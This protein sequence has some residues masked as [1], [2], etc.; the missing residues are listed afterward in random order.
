MTD[1][2][3][4]ASTQAIMRLQTLIAAL[5]DGPLARA[6]SLARLGSAYPPDD[7]ARPTIRFRY[8]LAAMLAQGEISR[9]FAE[10]RVVEHLPDGSVIIEAEGRNAFF[11]VRT[12]LRYAGNAELLEPDWLR[13][14]MITAVRELVEI[15]R[16]DM[17]ESDP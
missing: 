16:D 3:S 14:Q 6:E 7:S 1:R 5:R 17:L 13:A 11:I 10:Q 12:L 4:N 9:R 8:R 2:F 15:Y